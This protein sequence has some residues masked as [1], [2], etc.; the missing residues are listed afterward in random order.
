[1]IDLDRDMSARRIL[2]AFAVIGAL[3]IFSG[4]LLLSVA[5]MLLDPATP[6][7]TSGGLYLHGTRGAQIGAGVFSIVVSTM[8][9]LIACL[10]RFY[11]ARE[12]YR[13][14]M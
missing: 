11:Y 3:H 12:M 1:M 7:S 10:A 13:Y 14:R 5:V 2:R 4:I 8:V 9:I 6:S